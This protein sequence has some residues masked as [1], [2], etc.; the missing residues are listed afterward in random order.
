MLAA[1]DRYLALPDRERLLYRLG[2]RGGL[3][4]SVDDLN[5]LNDPAMRQRLESALRELES[6]AGA[7][8]EEFIRELAD[9]YI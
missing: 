8:V 1:I 5:D 6:G 7:G 4:R 3:L 2:R 9:R